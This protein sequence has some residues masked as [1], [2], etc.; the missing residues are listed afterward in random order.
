MLSHF[1]AFLYPQLHLYNL[2]PC[3]L[4]PPGSCALVGIRTFLHPHT[5][6]FMCACWHPYILTYSGSC[7]FG[8]I[9]ASS[10]SHVVSPSSSVLACNLAPSHPHSL[11]FICALLV[12]LPPHILS[13]MCV[14][15][16]PCILSP[17]YAQIRV[18]LLVSLHP[19]ILWPLGPRR[20]VC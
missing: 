5:L 10:H 9:L 14:S 18:C 2:A 16:Y 17:S 13:F 3:I 7:V 1:H 11:K 20:R 15:F 19:Y 4:I 12:S 6:R 8:C